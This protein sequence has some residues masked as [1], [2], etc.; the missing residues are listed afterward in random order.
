M[1]IPDTKIAVTLFNLR[2]YCQTAKELDTTL[3]KIKDIGY[4][5][6]QISGIG[7]IEPAEIKKLLDKHQMY[8]CATHENLPNLRD[9]FNDIVAKMKLWECDFTALG[10]PGNDCWSLEGMI[11]LAKELNEIGAKFKAESLKLGYHNHHYEF[12]KY[13]D[14]T[15]LKEIY[16]R[17][18]PTNLYAEIDVH[19]VSRGGGSP[20]KWIHNVAG[21][22]PVVHFKDFVIVNNEPVFCEIGEGNLDWQAII[23]ACENTGV[24]WYSIEQDS[25]FGDRNIFDSIEISFNNLKAMGVE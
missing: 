15:F 7:P 2:D 20:V 1:K 13:S 11:N 4:Q 16:E 21:R 14:K 9:N 22:M 6:V 8:C 3:G 24:R 25:P 5:A 18:D 17:T 19:W 12:V 10:H 23:K